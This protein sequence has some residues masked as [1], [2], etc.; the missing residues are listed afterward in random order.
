MTVATSDLAAGR[1]K[2]ILYRDMK[3]YQAKVSRWGTSLG[4]RIP[5]E[6]VDHYHIHQE[7]NVTIIPEE[8]G[9]RIIP[10]G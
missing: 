8:K 10:A 7:E 9:L 5:Q 2:Y 6:L 4:I 3:K 1:I